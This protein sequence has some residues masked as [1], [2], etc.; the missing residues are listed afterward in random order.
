MRLHGITAAVKL[1]VW[2]LMV[3]LVVLDLPGSLHR[4]IYDEVQ[5]GVKVVRGETSQRHSSLHEARLTQGPRASLRPHRSTKQKAIMGR[6]SLSESSFPQPIKIKSWIP[7]ESVHLSETEDTRLK[8]AVEEAVRTVSS[9]LSVNRTTNPLLLSRDF[10]KYCKFVWK[11]SSSVN[12]NRCGKANRYYRNETCLDV[13]IPDDHLAGCDVYPEADS[14]HR[15]IL[16]PEGAGLPDVDFVLYLQIKATD[17]CRAEPDVLA[18]AAQCQTDMNGRPVAG[19]VVVCRNRLTEATYSHQT[20][21]QT[22]IH[23]LFHALGF[24][25]D[26]FNTWKD[27]SSSNKVG[28]PCSSRGKVTHS[29]GSGQTRIYSPS[30]ISVMQKHLV[31]SDPELGGPLENLDAAAEGVSSHWESRVLQGSIMGAV[32]GDSTTIRIDPVTLAA[33]QDTGWYTVDLRLAQSLVWGEG[34]GKSFGS[35]KTCKHAS[36]FFCTGSGLGC[37]FLHLHKGE[38]QT[39]PYLDGCRVYKPLKKGSECWK[40]ESSRWSDENP[41]SGEMFGF[42]SR[43]FF[44]SLSREGYLVRT[45]SS[46]VGRCYRHRCT[47]T[48][49]YQI[50]VS[51]STWVDCPAGGAVQIKGYHGSV[52]CPDKRICVYPDVSPPLKDNSTPSSFIKWQV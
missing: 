50:Q 51:G 18:Y 36:S 13:I 42:D 19:A 17:K 37:H 8:T 6:S 22:V 43:C 29:D 46:I 41:Q 31:S 4:C 12:H 7:M 49:R 47:G 28:P 30:V 3:V 20:A 2:T 5:A 52:F 44:S 27:C 14:P 26:L 34:E 23:E 33:F 25:K 16:R 32:L 48:N 11:N 45:N 9:I 24:S 39:D 10:S 38:C 15:T 35:I 21:V 1:K 40:T